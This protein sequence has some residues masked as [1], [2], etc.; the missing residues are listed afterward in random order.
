MWEGF[1]GVQA[2]LSKWGKGSK[3]DITQSCVRLEII[4]MLQITL[5]A[6]SAIVVIFDISTDVCSGIF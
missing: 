2:L 4:E 5:N 6:A 3:R 1:F